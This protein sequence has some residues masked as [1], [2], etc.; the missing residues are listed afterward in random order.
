MK[1]S[2]DRLVQPVL[3]RLQPTV[4]RAAGF[5]P[6]RRLLFR[7]YDRQ[8]TRLNPV[9]P[10]DRQYHVDTSGRLHGTVLGLRDGGDLRTNNRYA[11]SQPSIIRAAVN[12]IPDPERV[13]FVDIGCGKGR[14]LVVASE[15]PF[16]EI[17][18]IEISPELAKI[19][20]RNAQTIAHEHPERAPITVIAGDAL[21]VHNLPSG[22]LVLY[23]YNPFGQDLTERLLKNIEY[24]L[25]HEKRTIYVVY[26]N[27]VWA[28][29]FDRSALLRRISAT[30][31]PC[32]AG[33][34][35]YGP[36]SSDVVIIWQDSDNAPSEV[37]IEASRSI[38]LTKSGFH[39]ELSGA[40]HA[41][42]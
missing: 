42:G 19:A 8:S 30:D 9:H 6:L 28:Q 15:F 34:V 38:I 25:E 10:F 23:L 26:Y 31:I 3:S 40:R 17:V 36:D 39:T 24:A 29:V 20:E 35:D 27:P 4:R 12:L 33:E 11:G 21:D 1:R 32:A 2:A 5:D 41:D 37:P 14:A 22:D 18:G 16:R 13:A 7:Y